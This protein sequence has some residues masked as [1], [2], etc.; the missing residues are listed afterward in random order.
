M[1]RTSWEFVKKRIGGGLIVQ[2]KRFRDY[3]FTCG[4]VHNWIVPI[5]HAV[6]WATGLLF[7]QLAKNFFTE[8]S[9]EEI[10]VIQFLAIF[11]ILFLEVI[12]VLLD[13]YVVQRANYLNPRFIL[14]VIVI[15][16]AM[17]G[18][19]I[20]AAMAFTPYVNMSKMLL[21][22][23]VFSSALKFTENLL[24][25]NSS[26]YIVRI[27]EIFDARGTYIKRPLS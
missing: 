13:I 20:S 7:A 11:V 27:P 5:L 17:L 22:V 21:Y 8:A 23:I 3:F 18:T 19:A 9:N 26:W 6:L 24:L 12:I 1:T 25:N 14:F 10:E 2:A 16:I 15:L 4:F